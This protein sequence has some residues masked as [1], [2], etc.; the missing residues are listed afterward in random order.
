MKQIAMIHKAR[1]FGKGVSIIEISAINQVA[2]VV[3]SE[4][5]KKSTME[6][7][8]MLGLHIPTPIV[9]KVKE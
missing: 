1:R 2:I 3:V 6:Y 9:R 7:A 5:H 8:K 4:E